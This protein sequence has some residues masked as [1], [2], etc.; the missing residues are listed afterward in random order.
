MAAEYFFP[1]YQVVLFRSGNCTATLELNKDM[2]ITVN[3]MF[4]QGQPLGQNEFLTYGGKIICP[5][6]AAIEL[7]T[8]GNKEI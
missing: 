8:Q 6:T 2:P 3:T 4:D 1:F 7:F 5:P